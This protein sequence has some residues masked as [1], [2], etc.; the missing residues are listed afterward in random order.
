MQQHKEQNIKII[1]EQC[2]TVWC[3]VSGNSPDFNPLENLWSLHK[4][5]LYKEPRPTTREML[6]EKVQEA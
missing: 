6:I 5:E 4:N 2:L 1:E 3:Q